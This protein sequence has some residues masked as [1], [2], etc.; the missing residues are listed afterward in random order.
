MLLLA[1]VM[2]N[3]FSSAVCVRAMRCSCASKI[4]GEL[5]RRSICTHA[6][7]ARACA[8]ASGRATVR[9]SCSFGNV[10]PIQSRIGGPWAADAAQRAHYASA[11]V[12]E[13]PKSPEVS[14]VSADGM[15]PECRAFK[16][17][18]LLCHLESCCVLASLQFFSG[19]V[20]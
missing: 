20:I 19:K 17:V 1:T 9:L 15:S 11:F 14:G 2:R 10:L 12:S 7:G 6:H 5:A 13:G 3:L 4:S 8:R 16:Y 18:A